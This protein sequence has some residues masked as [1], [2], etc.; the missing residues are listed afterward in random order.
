MK[1]T[2]IS[3]THNQHKKIEKD[4]PGGDLII[5]SGDISSMGHFHEIKSFLTWYNYLPGYKY[6]VFISGNHDFGF[7]KFPEEVRELLERYP[8]IK[9]L[10]DNGFTIF[11]NIG[12]ENGVKIWGTPW[13]PWFYD[14]AFNLPRDGE[15]LKAKWDM[16]PE[17]TD[18]LITHGPPKYVLDVVERRTEHLGCELLT[19]RLKVVKPK[20]HIFGHIHSGRGKFENNGTIFVNGSVLDEQY[21]YNYKPISIDYDFTVNML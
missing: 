13:Q 7:Q 14:W 3:D 5:H 11:D 12:G 6:K 10:E 19:E 21:Q 15:E 2:F 18:I 9:Y 4:L 8:N 16:I 1:I 20:I 17:D